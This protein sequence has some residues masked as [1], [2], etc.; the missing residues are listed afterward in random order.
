MFFN[1]LKIAWRALGQNR[2]HAV[3]NIGGL[4]LGLGSVMLILLYVQ[5]DLSFDRFHAQGPRLYRLVQD[6]LEQHGTLRKMGNTG[7]PQGPAFKAAVPEIAE[8]CRIKNG[9]NTLVRKGEEAIEEK[10]L[11]TD[12]ALLRMF[13]FRTLAGNGQTALSTPGQVLIT[14]RMAAKYF[15]QSDPV[16]QQLL[17]GDEGGSVF[18]PFTVGAVLAHPPQNSSIQFDLLL[19]LANLFAQDPAQRAREQNWYHAQLNTFLLLHPGA[20]PAQAS[21]KMAAVAAKHLAAAD[22]ANQNNPNARPLAATVGFRLQALFDLHLDPAYFAT[23]G[24]EFWSNAL[25]PKVLSGL[26]LFILL[27]ACINFI[28]LSLARALQRSK[29]IGIRKATGGTRGQL[30][31]Q[32]M[33][34]SFLCCLLAFLPALLLARALLPAFGKMMDKHLEAACLFQPSTLLALGGLLLLVTFLAGFYPAMVLSGLHPIESL[35]G[36]A[37]LGKRRTLGTAL[38]VSQFAIAGVLIIGATVANRQFHYIATADLG[39][40]TENILRFWLPWEQIGDIAAPLK[41]ELAQLPFVERVSAKSG[42]WNSTSYNI[43]GTRTDG[44]YYEHIDEQHLQLM[45]IPLVAGRHLSYQHALDTVSNIVVNEAFVREFLPPGQDP[46]E[47]PLR[48]G[49]AQLRIVGIAKDFHYASFKERIRPMVWILDNAAQAGCVHL[50]IAPQHRQEALAAIQA[51]YK[52]YVP[53]LPLE[54][55]FLEDFRMQK[56]ADD[57]RWKQMLDYATLLAVLIACL[58]LFGLA[59]FSAEQRTKE[60]GIRKVLGASVAGVAGLLAKDFLKLVLIAILVASPLAWYLLEKWLA[61]FAYRIDMQWWMFAAAGA[62]AVAIATLTV[63][64]QALRAALANPAK[65]LRSE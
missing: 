37:R 48:Q 39:Y 53:Y 7:L 33:G 3:I 22:A 54:Y 49:D 59:A 63:G 47:Q 62:V 29:E 5:D 14:D 10:L 20:D 51:V 34:E 38:V 41:R 4:A 57:L 15:G 32:F 13:S 17:I 23:H 21:Q 40:R 58:G 64:G 60:I 61:D 50:Q 30:L 9:W 18:R 2:L 28:N 27:L 31:L 26:G 24:L 42:D 6:R 55:F 25:Y 35:K 43:N 8:F 44:V 46:F 56:Y 52:K 1:H 16:G 12:D 65:S 11:Y 36:K 19:P 45:G